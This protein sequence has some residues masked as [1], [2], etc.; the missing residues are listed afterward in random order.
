VFV[1][2]NQWR[3]VTYGNGM[4][5][6]VASD[7][8]N[9]VMYSVNGINWFYRNIPTLLWFAVAYGDGMFIA[10]AQD[11]AQGLLTF[12]ERTYSDKSKITSKSII[13]DITTTILSTDWT[14]AAPYEVNIPLSL[15]GEVITSTTHDIRLSI[16]LDNNIEIA[17]QE[18]EAYSYFSK[19]EISNTNV[20]KITCFDYKPA[21][22]LN[23]NLE[24]VKKW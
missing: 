23:L 19:G 15:L 24:V 7:G 8:T 3:S 13:T 12:G 5:V 20:L 14:G 10:L 18:Q 4:F 1:E 9:R 16:V 22:D 11:S 21:V 17:K 2:L 6:A